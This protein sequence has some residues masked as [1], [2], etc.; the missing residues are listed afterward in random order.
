MKRYIKSYRN[1]AEMDDG[2]ELLSAINREIQNLS[3][4]YQKDNDSYGGL[5]WVI[6]KVKTVS[7]PKIYRIVDIPDKQVSYILDNLKKTKTIRENNGQVVLKVD[8]PGNVIDVKI[9]SNM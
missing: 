9:P 3:K 7:G 6:Y 5:L 1:F 4:Q 8:Y 2:D